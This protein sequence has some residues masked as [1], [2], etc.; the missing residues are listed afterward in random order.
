[1]CQAFFLGETNYAKELQLKYADIIKALFIEPNPM[2]IKDAMN[3][4]GMDVGNTRLPLV[5][6]S[7]DTHEILKSIIYELK[8]K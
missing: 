4:L 3:I 1:M 8:N 6:V 2:P 5:N 7:D